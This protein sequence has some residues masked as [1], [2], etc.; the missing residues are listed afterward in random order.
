MFWTAVACAQNHAP[1]V[2]PV[3]NLTVA[4]ASAQL[5][6]YLQNI[7]TDPDLQSITGN[8]VR[9]DT[10]NGS[11]N[12]EMFDTQTP[13]T[14]TN[15]L[16]YVSGGLF[17]NS[18]VHRSIPN[19][20]IQSGGFTINTGLT[21][22]VPIPITTFPAIPNEPG[23]SNVRGTVAMAKLG[24]DP[25]SA[26]SQWYINLADNS[27]NLDAQNGGFTVF[28]RVIEGGMTVADALIRFA[29][30]TFD[31]NAQRILATAFDGNFQTLP[32]QN[33]TTTN[34]GNRKKPVTANYVLASGVVSGP[35]M[36]FSVSSD[37]IGVVNP[38]LNGL[39]LT[40]IPVA[41]GTATV[42]VT[43]R[44][45]NGLTASSVSTVSVAPNPPIG[46]LRNI[47]TRSTVQTGEKVMIGGFIVEGT[48]TKRLLIRVLGSELSQFGV[49]SILVDPFL[50]LHD[51]NSIIASNNTWTIQ[52]NPADVAAI[53]ATPYAP[54][55]MQE[56]A[57]LVTVPAGAYTVVVS[58]V[59]GTSGNALVEVYE[60]DA[61]DTARLT[62]IS[63]RGAVGTGDDVMIGGF[64][65][66]GTTPKR[67]I[68]RAIGPTLGPLGIV[69][70][71]LDPKLE[72]YFG[73]QL[74]AQNDNWQLAPGGGAN[75]DLAA[76]I[77]SG[78]APTSD[79]ESAIILTLPPG[80]YTAIV[81]G[82]NN[83]SG[84]GM[85]EVYDLD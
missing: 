19:F 74:I 70:P 17:T 31:L 32:L 80:A 44:D 57:V 13:Q 7:F 85:V 71:L 14:V 26:T 36:T 64:I 40:L 56:P 10:G 59:G 49:P 47:S 79:S 60:L 5:T 63:T 6:F 23:L 45:F 21:N 16:R 51:A 8:Q 53:Q 2:T 12:L 55:D 58:G 54:T 28:G 24:G 77:A 35:K 81:R 29:I 65:V 15:F 33:Y 50:E 30:K 27:A 1:V 3:P 20:I 69:N 46:N 68:V 82:A 18:I 9:I 4:P 41:A 61:T 37:N 66:N 34:F 43:A 25:N 78:H 67:V 73:G 22:P 76:I 39:A 38:L 84:V 11:I 42:T 75:P 72:V 52:T 62:N 48:G 83:T